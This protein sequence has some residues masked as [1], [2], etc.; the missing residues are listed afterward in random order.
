M[1]DIVNLMIVDDSSRARLALRAFLSLQAG[2]RIIAQASNGLEA[3][4]MI[5]RVVPDVVLMDMKMPVMDGLEAT[6]IIK[7]NWP[8]VKVIILSMYSDYL[9]EAILSGADK[10]LVKGC[11]VEEIMSAITARSGSLSH[12]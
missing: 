6:R 11:S 1:T 12:M 10:F 9:G 4:D 5:R 8:G 3:V 2:V 7:R